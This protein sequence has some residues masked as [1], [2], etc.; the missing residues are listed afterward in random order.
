VSDFDDVGK[1]HRKFNLPVASDGLPRELT[2]EELQFRFRFMLEELSEY[3]E[4]MGVT[5]EVREA[6]AYGNVQKQD[7]P[8]A[9]DALI[10]LVYVALGT[11]HLH[12]FPWQEGWDEVQRANVAK[13]RCGIDHKFKDCADEDCGVDPDFCHEQISDATGTMDDLCQMTRKQ[14]SL[15]GSALDVIKT[16]G[17]KAPDIAQVLARVFICPMCDQATSVPHGVC[18]I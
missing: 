6:I 1:F 14:H 8:K 13:E 16:P 7:L 3:A 10:D 18:Q 17:W 9:F 11:A 2:I 15:R 5:F 12:R 4:A